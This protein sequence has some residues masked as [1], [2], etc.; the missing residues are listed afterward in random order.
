MTKS[1]IAVVLAGVLASGCTIIA[2][3]T[4]ALAS[5]GTSKETSAKV[6]TNSFYIGLAA[7]VVAAVAI[8]AVASSMQGDSD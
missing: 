1:L 8:F 3:M 6:V 2:P 5:A 7:D 4:G